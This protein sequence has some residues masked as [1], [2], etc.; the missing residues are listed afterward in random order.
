MQ[1]HEF[2]NGKGKASVLEYHVNLR[3]RYLQRQILCCHIL[4]QTAPVDRHTGHPG[5]HLTFLEKHLGV[6][7]VD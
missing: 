3:V 2:Q 6:A 1:W 5:A 4:F 7:R